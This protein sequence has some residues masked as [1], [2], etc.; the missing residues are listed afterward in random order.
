MIPGAALIS[1]GLALSAAEIP[2]DLRAFIQGATGRSAESVLEG[3]DSMRW[4]GDRLVIIYKN[5][6]ARHL[7]LGQ[8][9]PME[10]PT[11]SAAPS[12]NEATIE[13]LQNRLA[14]ISFRNRGKS[15][16]PESLGADFDAL[17]HLGRDYI[18]LLARSPR[19][20]GGRGRELGK[21]GNL[22]RSDFESAGVSA[23]D[24]WQGIT[25]YLRYLAAGP[26]LGQAQPTDEDKRSAIATL[27]A[28]FHQSEVGQPLRVFSAEE[29]R[30]LWKLEPKT[31]E[32]LLS[33]NKID[34]EALSQVD[35]Q[36]YDEMANAGALRR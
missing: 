33:I 36:L 13:T 4:K 22:F 15:L 5:G 8:A 30:P 27:W 2:E 21:F 7:I 19:T 32:L 9:L 35:P 23:A 26:D 3:H 17:R 12:G 6:T 11:V 14:E 28:L 18:E 20:W 16:D 29:I 1:F 25:F 24:P 31:L 10:E 34:A